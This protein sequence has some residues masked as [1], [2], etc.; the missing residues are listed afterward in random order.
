[1]GNLLIK[2]AHIVDNESTKDIL[3]KNGIIGKIDNKLKN[4]GQYKE[5]DAKGRVVL[6]TLIESHIHPDK[7]FLE[8]RMP[9][10]SGTLEEAIKNTS[11]LKKKY[12]KPLIEALGS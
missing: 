7:A 12:T 8:E 6:P 9:N 11:E 4:E 5:I 1:M 2:N 3:I 10:K